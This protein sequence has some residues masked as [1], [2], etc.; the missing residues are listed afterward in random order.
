MISA[1]SF[2]DCVKFS[3]DISLNNSGSFNHSEG[4]IVS[5]MMREVINAAMPL[6]IHEDHW[7][8]AK[9][10][11]EPILGKVLFNCLYKIKIIL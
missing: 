6:Y 11:L 1:K 8:M 3:L 5:G 9:L 10:W 7:K 2:I 4:N